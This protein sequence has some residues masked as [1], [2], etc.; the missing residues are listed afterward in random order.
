MALNEIEFVKGVDKLHAF[1]TE[2]VRMLARA[3]DLT[4]RQAA[5]LLEQYGYHNVARSILY[6][7]RV[8][9]IPDSWGDD[10]QGP[11]H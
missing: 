1:Y 8:H 3:Y 6:P 9:E 7:P 2:Q 10:R 5:A 11:A 4:D